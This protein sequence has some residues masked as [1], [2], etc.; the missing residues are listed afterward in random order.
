MPARGTPHP[1]FG[2][3]LPQGPVDLLA[4]ILGSRGLAGRAKA[5]FFAA[6]VERSEVG[7][8]GP[9]PDPLF[10][11]EPCVSCGARDSLTPHRPA[12]AVPAR[13]TPINFLRLNAVHTQNHSVF[14]SMRPRI[15]N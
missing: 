14:T 1:A 7:R 13:R 6:A 3:P 4:A 2:H 5:H 8:A 10:V 11:P 15:R 12:A 9:S